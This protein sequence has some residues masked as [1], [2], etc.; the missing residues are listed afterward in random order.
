TN[1]LAAF[2]LPPLNLLLLLGVGLLLLRHH[3]KIGKALVVAGFGLLWLL[4]TP[5][6]VE[7]GMHFLE[8]EYRPV[9]YP[10]ADD[11]QAIVILGGSLYFHAPEYGGR[12]T[13]S[14]TTL[15]RLSYGAE[16]QRETGLP[17]L[18]TG[19]AVNKH[20]PEG[21]L[22]QQRMQKDFQVPVR[23]VEGKA[24]NTFENARFSAEILKRENIHKVY[25]VTHAW[26]MPRSVLAFRN[27][28]LEVIPAPLAFTTRYQTDVFSFI[29]S[30]EALWQAK[31][32]LHEGIGLFWYRIRMLVS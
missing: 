15:Q 30:T 12:D 10:S 18:V 7:S 14:A 8:S 2:L 19:G 21:V 6:V 5:I 13:V 3:P 28:G 24:I 4:S 22:M 32:L 23:W 1:F 25:L 26:H 11:A 29:P 20:L 27:A 9:L 16:L 17:V 31:V